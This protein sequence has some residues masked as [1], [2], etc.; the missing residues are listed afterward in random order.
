MKQLSIIK[1]Q[2]IWFLISGLIIAIGCFAMINNIS[3]KGVAF[4]LGIDFTGGTSLLLSIESVETQFKETGKLS[5]ALRSEINTKIRETL[6][7]H[8]ILHIQQTT[9]EKHLFA[10]KTYLVSQQSLNRPL[11]DLKKEIGS[12]KVLE[13]DFIGPTI[14]YE[15]KQQSIWIIIV[16]IVILLIY[17]TFRFEFYAA[18]AAIIALLHDALITL[19]LTAVLG[20]EVNTAFI[21]ALLTI[22]GYSINDT[23]V[24]FDRIRENVANVKGNFSDI[25]DLSINQTIVRSINT[26]ATTVVVLLAIYIF[27]GASLSDFALVLLIGIISGTYS[28]IFIASPI[29]NAFKKLS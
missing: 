23:I 13:T 9:V 19:G 5:S 25:V 16:A 14:G 20:L 26:S 15:L 27:G 11:D 4:D 7:K 2:F 29:L 17:I 22:L 6:G 21:A 3:K 24:I 10:I 18:L 8:G 12:F 1:T 28:S